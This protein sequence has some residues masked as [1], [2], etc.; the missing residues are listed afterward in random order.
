MYIRGIGDAAAGPG[1]ACAWYDNI[2]A[3]QGCLDWYAANDPT[4]PFYVTNTKGLIVGGA[5]VL[6]QTAGQAIAAGAN[7][8]LGLS[9][10][11][12]PSWVWLGAIAAAGIFILPKL[13]GR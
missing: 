6:G 10:T 4:N 7:S 13:V 5:Q 1:D 11:A 12:V 3:T 9:P 2:W 8:A